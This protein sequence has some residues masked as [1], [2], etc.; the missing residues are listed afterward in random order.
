[1]TWNDERIA[2]LRKLWDEG[3]SASIIGERL[4]ISKNAVVGKAHRLKLP[5]RPSP[6]KRGG[7]GSKPRRARKTTQGP[8]RSAALARSEAV[9]QETPRRQ[10]RQEASPRPP[11]S[12]AYRH[13]ADLGQGCLWPIGDPGQPDFHFCGAKRAEGRPYCDEH[14]ARAYI[15]RKNGSEAA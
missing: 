6:I 12:R 11:M 10:V 7:T 14:V 13:S 8:R 15:S 3:L 5:S 4:G 2:E 1:M 9:R